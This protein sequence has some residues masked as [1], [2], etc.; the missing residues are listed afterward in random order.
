[1]STANAVTGWRTFPPRGRS[2]DSFLQPAEF[3]VYTELKDAAEAVLAQSEQP[4]EFKRRLLRL[5][6]NATRDNLS[7]SD[8]RELIQR[9]E[10]DEQGE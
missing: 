9:A 3:S 7:D 1:M 5:I 6:E 8:L 4:E 10:V 2:A